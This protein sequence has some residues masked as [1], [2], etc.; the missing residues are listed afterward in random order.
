M[1]IFLSNHIVKKR[2]KGTLYLYY[3]DS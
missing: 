3:Y 2:K 1:I